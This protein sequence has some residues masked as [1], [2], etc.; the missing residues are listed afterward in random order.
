MS[1]LATVYRKKWYR[2][3]FILTLVLLRLVNNTAHSE[4][5]TSKHTD[6]IPKDTTVNTEPSFLYT[7]F[8]VA[9]LYTS[10]GYS[11]LNDNSAS[12][13]EVNIGFKKQ[14]SSGTGDYPWLEKS[15]GGQ[16]LTLGLSY[17]RY[18][19]EKIPNTLGI[20]AA[21]FKLGG[22][23][24]GES[25]GGLVFGARLNIFEKQSPILTNMLIDWI[26]YDF[27]LGY[28]PLFTLPSTRIALTTHLN[29]G[30]G[31]LS[32]DTNILENLPSDRK[33]TYTGLSGRA[34]ARL[35]CYY[36]SLSF[37]TDIG[38]VNYALAVT[39]CI[40]YTFWKKDEGDYW[41]YFDI[42]LNY[43]M[44]NFS[45]TEDKKEIYSKSINCIRAGLSFRLMR[46]LEKKWL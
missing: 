27:D 3:T 12:I 4:T 20:N 26:S 14:I 44:N 23:F 24:A 18:G 40:S 25:L 46:V 41:N 21:L 35:S 30:L 15:V 16:F 19:N 38:L 10:V 42:F 28:A 39:S 9:P 8:S 31:S 7:L 5:I 32:L 17:K 22:T 13:S 34:S 37:Y 1:R 6:S 29:L 2:I 43:E 33:G 11:H 36:K 45:I